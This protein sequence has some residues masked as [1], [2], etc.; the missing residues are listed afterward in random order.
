M[1]NK[2]FFLTLVLN[3]FFALNLLGDDIVTEYRLNGIAGIAKSLDKALT[4]KSYW[5]EH[6]RDKGTSFGY[7]ESYPN[8]LVCNKAE[9]TLT[10]YRKDL[11]NSY[12][13]KK[14]YSAYT[15]KVKGD[16]YKEGDLK[17]PVGI[18]NITKKISQVDSFYGPMAFVTSYPNIYDRYQG[19]NGSG[20]W[21][22]GL[23]T[24]QERDE[25]T[26]GCIAINNQ[27]IECL[28]RNID[29]SKTLLVI[30]AEEV[31]KNVSKEK[32]SE[33]LSQLYTWR[34]TWIYNKLEDYLDFYADGFRRFDGMNKTRFSRYKSRIF[35]KNEEKTIHFSDINI[36]PYPNL[37]ET[38]KITF[39]EAYQSNSF[40]FVGNKI[41]IVKLVENK[42]K[43]ITE[44]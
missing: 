36:V 37:E 42:L 32:L 14:K 5:Q 13:V 30:S 3:T 2:V 23:P 21:I 34:Y 29:I 35:S 38:Y 19:K 25:F 43:I 20:I 24:E 12:S 6:L 27:S 31:Y 18:Y 8:I 4:E 9:S 28:D 17:T 15:G 7:I 10:L 26:K 1:H 44:Q 33:L 16:K 41:L 39:K 22:H 40:T 11:N